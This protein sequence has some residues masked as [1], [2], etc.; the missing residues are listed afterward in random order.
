[1]LYIIIIIILGL[2][3]SGSCVS[4]RVISGC[5]WNWCVSVVKSVTVEFGA[6]FPSGRCLQSLRKLLISCGIFGPE[7]QTV[8]SSA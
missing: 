1:M 5:V 6:S 7:A 3:S 4:P 2:R 8:M